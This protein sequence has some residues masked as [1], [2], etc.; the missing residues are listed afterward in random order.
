MQ[1]NMTTMIQC[2]YGVTLLDFLFFKK[3][4]RTKWHYHE[5]RQNKGFSQLRRISEHHTS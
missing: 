4:K 2:I 1:Q 3:K 5:G